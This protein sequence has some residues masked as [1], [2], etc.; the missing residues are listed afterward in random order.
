MTTDNN[1]V[2]DVGMHLGEDS[3]FYLRKGFRVVALEAN[4]Q[5][6]EHCKVRFRDA[7]EAKHLHIVEGAVA[8]PEAGDSIAFYVSA[9]SVWGTAQ[10]NWRERNEAITKINVRRIDI[11]DVFSRFG[12]PHFMKVDIEGADVVVLNALLQCEGRPRYLS[13]EAEKVDFEAL[14]AEVSLL[15]RLGYENFRAVQQQG[16][17]GRVLHTKTISGQELVYTFEEHA[18]GPFGEDLV[19]P[20]RT[21]EQILDEYRRIYK[22]YRLFGDRS[23]TR[24]LQSVVIRRIVKAGYMIATGYRGPLPGWYDTHA[25][26]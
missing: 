25:S 15:S 23:L 9:Q 8:P 26:L 5:L 21:S 13:I 19:Q 12:I 2:F 16:I 18:S 4:P 24:R 17:P 1:L 10:M 6:I 22:I 7:I 11:H 14:R 20:W 3:D